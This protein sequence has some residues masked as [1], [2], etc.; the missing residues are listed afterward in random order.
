MFLNRGKMKVCAII[1]AGGLG[2]RMG[3]KSP[4]QFLL[5]GRVPVIIHTIRAFEKA[6]SI[7]RIL[8]VLPESEME[9]SK[10]LIAGYGPKKVIRLTAGGRERQDSVRNGL[11]AVEP[12]IDMILVHDGVR[13][14][15]SEELIDTAVSEAAKHGAVSVGVPVK[16]TIKSTGA[17]F[18]VKDTL[19][20]KNLW[21]TQTPQVFK[22]DILEEAYK[23]AYA[24]A[25]FGTD[26]ASLVERLG[27]P[28]VMV[29]GSYQ[30][31]K[32]T[33][34]EDLLYGEYILNQ[35]GASMKVGIGYDSHRLVEGRKLILGGIDIPFDKGLEGHSDADALIHAIIDALLGAAGAGDIG[36]HFPDSDPE[37]RGISSMKLLEKI[38]ILFDEKDFTISHID[39]SIILEK[40]KLSPFTNLMKN[41]I[42]GA[43]GILPSSV[44]IK[45]KTNDG[46]GFVG[47][48]E[49]VAVIATAA[50]KESMP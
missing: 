8:L 41:N 32:I 37:Y 25:Y 20:R 29:P 11:M 10:E 28:V 45:A 7:D 5:L 38:K 9:P 18:R 49:G 27:I 35:R 4:K 15:V 13:P 42:A 43:L 23:R 46:M 44:N 34:P 47:R 22:R 48:K 21:I 16:D 17:D 6:S 3:A 19:D 33:T 1:V 36:G 26:D 39:A 30:N 24:D 40:P 2:K 12:D 50:V 14:F 31:M